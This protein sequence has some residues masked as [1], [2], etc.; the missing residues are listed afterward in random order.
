MSR[1]V[2]PVGRRWLAEAEKTR[3]ESPPRDAEHA[4]DLCLVP[5]SPIHSS[6]NELTLVRM[7]IEAGSQHVARARVAGTHLSPWRRWGSSTLIPCPSH[8]GCAVDR[9]HSADL[10]NDN[11]I[12][13]VPCGNPKSKSL[14]RLSPRLHTFALG[15]PIETPRVGGVRASC[16]GSRS[17]GTHHHGCG[18]SEQAI[19][20]DSA[21]SPPGQ[22]CTHDRGGEIS[23]W[24]LVGTSRDERI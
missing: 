11:P 14:C 9:C 8:D 1:V 17:G 3:V 21:N 2:T 12:R 19:F 15:E 7:Q 5:A 10:E 16:A 22:S 4:R 23:S 6:E 24:F 20:V 18:V 13:S